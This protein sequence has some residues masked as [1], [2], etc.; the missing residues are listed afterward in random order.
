MREL[1][2]RLRKGW[3]LLV[4][5]AA[6]LLGFLLLIN[7]LGTLTSSGPEDLLATTL[8][9]ERHVSLPS[10]T[11]LLTFAIGA[12]GL[13]L[14]SCPSL[15][16]SPWRAGRTRGSCAATSWADQRWPSPCR[17]GPVPGL[18]GNPGRR[19]RLQ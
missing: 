18:L 1:F 5:L 12:T 13:I 19:R 11:G 4:L 7:L 14:G 2:G 15:V 8:S 9:E 6:A 17:G 3:G 16:P 10:G